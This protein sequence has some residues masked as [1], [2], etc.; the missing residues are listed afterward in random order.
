MILYTIV[1]E[2]FVLAGLDLGS[3]GVV[4]WPGESGARLEERVTAGVSG[5]VRLLVE[6]A[7]PGSGWRV[8][9]LLSSDPDDY[10]N[11]AFAP[12]REFPGPGR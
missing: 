8:N 11:P 12:G 10:L 9:R 7:S 2:E 6:R 3:S 5:P 4:G 1:P